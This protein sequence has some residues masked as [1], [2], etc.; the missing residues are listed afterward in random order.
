MTLF[1]LHLRKIFPKSNYQHNGM[2]FLNRVHYL[3][4]IQNQVTTKWVFQRLSTIVGD[5]DLKLGL[6]TL[7]KK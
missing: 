4:T 5:H 1:G 3:V 2:F 6:I 7:V